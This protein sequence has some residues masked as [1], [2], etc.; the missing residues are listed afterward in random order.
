MKKVK[1]SEIIGCLDDRYIEEAARFAADGSEKVSGRGTLHPKPAGKRTYRPRWVILAACLMLAIGS[2]VYAFAAEA[3]EYDSAMTF[4]EE[5]GLSAEGLSRSDVKAVYRDI[6]TRRFTCGKTADILRQTVPGQEIVR[7]EP[8]PEELAALWDKNVRENAESGTGYSYKRDCSYVRDEK[9]GFEVFEKSILKC[10]LDGSTLW[11]A[12]F[13]GVFADGWA[14]TA[15]G[16]AVWGWNETRYGHAWLARVDDGGS[17]RWARHLDHGFEWEGIAAV[18]D[19]GDGTWA[20]FSRGDL[21]YLCLT[22]LD[23]DGEE[24]SFR[25]TEVGNLGIWN[26]ARLGEGYI[27]Q[28]GNMTTRDTAL[29]YTM[30]REGRLLDRY[31]YESGECE[32]YLEDMIEFSGQVYL[33]AYAVPLQDDEGGRHEIADVLDYIFAKGESGW[34]ITSE[35]LTPIVRDNYTAVLLICDPAGGTPKTFYSVQGSLGGK[36]A[37]NGAG[38]L[39]WDVKSIASTFF[40]PATSSFTIGG[41]CNVFRYT[42]D[43]EGALIGQADTGETEAYRR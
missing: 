22:C 13:A 16:T 37:V 3:R 32:Y 42:F 10:S 7:S 4:F 17:V 38:Q 24:L 26:A 30:D 2:A 27:V 11:T 23:A 33:S 29:L 21:K 35:E 28:L 9:Q 39:E 40:S 25:Q 1:V 31:S 41:T 8:T 5:N 18:L 19:N 43:V 6:T 20:V 14:H 15:L 36:L 12:E 34:N